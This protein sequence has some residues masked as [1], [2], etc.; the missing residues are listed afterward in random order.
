MIAKIQQFDLSK[1]VYVESES[2]RIGN[3]QLPSRLW[4]KMV[5]SPM[6]IIKTPVTERANYLLGVYDHLSKEK[7][8]IIKLINGMQHRHGKKITQ[9]WQGLFDAEDWVELAKA[10]LT[11]H[12]DPA[13]DNSVGRHERKVYKT[14]IQKNCRPHTISKTAD[15]ILNL[16][17][18]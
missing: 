15:I 11:D 10:L 9:K 14:I 7:I 6:V 4:K 5:E 3:L 13:Y 1:P 18:N 12:Y 8:D 2:S 16:Q 17:S